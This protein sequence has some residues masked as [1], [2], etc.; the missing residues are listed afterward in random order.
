MFESDRH[1]KLRLALEGHF[2]GLDFDKRRSGTTSAP[3]RYEALRMELIARFAD[4]R[5][6]SNARDQ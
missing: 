5:W 4:A 6:E 1:Q 2:R 3:C